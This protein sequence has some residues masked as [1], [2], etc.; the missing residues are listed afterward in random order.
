VLLVLG[1][2]VLV[3][4]IGAAIGLAV[5]GSKK[6]ED[7]VKDLARGPANCVTTLDVDSASTYY[8]YLESKGE[9][10]DI[11]GDCPSLGDSYDVSD[12]GDPALSLTD[13]DG[14]AVRLRRADGITYDTAGYSGEMV[15]SARLDE[16][17]YQLAVVADDDV[18][19]AVGRDVD[20]LKPNLVLP[21][22]L[23]A[24]GLLLGIVLIVL[25]R[26]KRPST[27]ATAAPVGPP[28]GLT[29]SGP[30]QPAWGTYQPPQP[31]PPPGAP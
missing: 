23:G 20:G 13:S 3:A 18:V 25:S 9:V 10:A 29:T 22:V 17:R 8:F 1:L 19:V 6:Y 31:G 15:N 14:E 27:P 26:G 5:A 4:G 24:I 2:V 12:V 7:G 30:G 11:R 28:A 21:I 16:G